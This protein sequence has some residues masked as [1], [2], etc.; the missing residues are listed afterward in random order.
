MEK[1]KSGERGRKHQERKTG[2]EIFLNVIVIV[3]VVVICD[4]YILSCGNPEYLNL[5]ASF[6]LV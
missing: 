6:V 2:P 4:F 3:I 5:Y 1:S